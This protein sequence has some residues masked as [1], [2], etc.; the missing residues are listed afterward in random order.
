MFLHLSVILF[1]RVVGLPASHDLEGGGGLH[2]GRVCPQGGGSASGG[3]ASGWGCIGGFCIQGFYIHR[4]WADPPE[5]Y[6]IR[7]TSG[8]YA[9]YWNTFLFNV[10]EFT[11]KNE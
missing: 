8:R 10:H 4:G 6:M 5:Y 11:S 9:S 1:T 7:S 3:S 2:P